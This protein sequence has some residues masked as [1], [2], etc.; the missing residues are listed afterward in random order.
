MDTLYRIKSLLKEQGKTQKELTDYI[1]I[2]K[3]V[4]S[5][6]KKGKSK[7]YKKYI[8]EIAEFFGVSTDSL[9]GI[10]ERKPIKV[11][12]RRKTNHERT[13]QSKL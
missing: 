10:R 7:S 13:Y 4:F 1:G 2:E 6:W 8:A 5:D 11:K 9:L 12:I 3:S